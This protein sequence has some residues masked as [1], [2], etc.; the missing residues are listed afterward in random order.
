MLLFC[1]ELLE[2]FNTSFKM[3][4][5]KVK[6]PCAICKKSTACQQDSIECIG[7]GLW[8]HAKCASLST[9]DIASYRSSNEFLCAV[10]ASLMKNKWTTWCYWTGKLIGNYFRPLLGKSIATWLTSLRRLSDSPST[11]WTSLAI[12]LDRHSYYTAFSPETMP[13]ATFG[14]QQIA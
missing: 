7:C 5:G 1:L 6:H 13:P 11:T 8:I 12:S 2:E 10:S 9:A 14:Q 3:L 4:R